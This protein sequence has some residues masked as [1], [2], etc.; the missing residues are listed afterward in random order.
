MLCCGGIVRRD[1]FLKHDVGGKG[2]EMVGYNRDG[3]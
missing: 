3:G 1:S 2:G